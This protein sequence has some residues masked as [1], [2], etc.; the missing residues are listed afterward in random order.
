MKAYIILS[1]ILL[2]GFTA[3]AFA[4]EDY[5]D[6]YQQTVAK[7]SVAAEK[8][9]QLEKQIED[10][11]TEKVAAIEEELRASNQRIASMSNQIQ[12]W[13]GEYEDLEEE[14][15]DLDGD[16]K[17]LSQ[18]YRDQQTTISQLNTIIKEQVDVIFK[19]VLGNDT[20]TFWAFPDT[21]IPVPIR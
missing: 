12:D 20:D 6:L 7:L 5:Q 18:K 4:E 3:P 9:G 1:A 11:D 21:S 14:Y 2:A 16:Y 19:W 10:V 8:I 13:E 17:K 15:W